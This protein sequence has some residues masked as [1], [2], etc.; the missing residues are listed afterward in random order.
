M[1][2]DQAPMTN[3]DQTW[4]FPLVIGHWSFSHKVEREHARAVSFPGLDRASGVENA[5]CW[6][7]D[8]TLPRFILFA[9]LRSRYALKASVSVF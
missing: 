9:L 6:R 7:I 2:N 1:T 5:F 3:E 8:I 4:F